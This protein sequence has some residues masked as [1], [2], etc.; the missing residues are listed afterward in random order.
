[1]NRT[2]FA[3]L[4]ATAVIAGFAGGFAVTLWN[5][6][7]VHAQELMHPKVLSAESFVLVNATG[8]KLGGMSVSPDG[9]ATL[10]L[11]DNQGKPRIEMGLYR[12]AGPEIRLL[13]PGG[14][15]VIWSA[16]GEPQVLPLGK[17]FR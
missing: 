9:S 5:A 7:P 15:R 3:L 14:R 16:P 11:Y 17:E 13:G 10:Q 4:V 1:M 6:P 12:S 8:E 2:F